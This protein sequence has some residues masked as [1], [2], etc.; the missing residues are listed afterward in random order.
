[1]CEEITNGKNLKF[2]NLLTE[3]IV[4]FNVHYKVINSIILHEH[5][6]VTKFK[7][8][9]LLECF[10]IQISLFTSVLETR[11]VVSQRPYWSLSQNQ[12]NKIDYN[13]QYT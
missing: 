5:I 8:E 9:L 12:C 1:M 10:V 3:C 7:L 11:A 4:T 2:N 6:L 13:N